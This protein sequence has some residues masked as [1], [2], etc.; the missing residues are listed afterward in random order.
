MAFTTLIVELGG[1]CML[2]L[3]TKD[4][5]TKG[6]Y[7]LMP[8][9]HHGALH[10]PLFIAEEIHTES[11]KGELAHLEMNEKSDEVDLR[12]M[13]DHYEPTEPGDPKVMLPPFVANVS[14]FY[15][16]LR[17]V[18]P[19]CLDAGAVHGLGARVILP[20]PKTIEPVDENEFAEFYVPGQDLGAPT[21]VK[22][23]GQ[24]RITYAVRGNIGKPEI[25]NRRVKGVELKIA[26]DPMK[27]HFV[28]TRPKDLKGGK[29]GH[30]A[31]ES[32][33]HPQAYHDLLVRSSSAKGPPAIIARDVA[34]P[35]DK[36]DSTQCDKVKISKWPPRK[37]GDDRPQVSFIDPFTCTLGGGCDDPN[38]PC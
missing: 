12:F 37:A 38:N 29:Y 19:A 18:N 3:R 10:C 8:A 32:W 24:C 21:F 6:L 9:S 30:G 23:H 17:L 34:G 35:E 22:L 20:I 13:A 33:E 26:Q 36:P 7:V 4:E 5:A 1:L 25:W 16:S 31:G 27:M 15:T 14:R 11:G 2:V 28:N